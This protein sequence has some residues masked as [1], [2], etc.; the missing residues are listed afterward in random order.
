MRLLIRAQT[1][2]TSTIQI[3]KITEL[4]NKANVMMPK[5]VTIAQETKMMLYI[6]NALMMPNTESTMLYPTL[7]L[8]T[9]GQLKIQLKLSS[10][11]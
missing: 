8:T 4:A 10:F 5:M 7:L 2:G 1:S 3:I 6:T 9:T 11:M